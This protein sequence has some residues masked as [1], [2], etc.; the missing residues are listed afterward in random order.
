MKPGLTCLA[1]TLLSLPAGALASTASS[2]A[3]LRLAGAITP[4]GAC[5]M[6]VGNGVI[7]FE[8]LSVADLNPDHSKP[9]SLEEQR[10]KIRIDCESPRRYALVARSSAPVGNDELDFGL[11]SQSDQ[12][13]AGRLHLRFDSASAHIEGAR[14]YY[15]AADAAVD[16]ATAQWGPSTFSIL[17]VPNGAFAIGF[18]TSDGSYATPPPIAHFDTYLLVNP[19]IRPVN[20]L[21][22]SSEIAFSGSIGFEI[23]Y[24]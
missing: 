3:N 18:V 2:S 11:F 13:V 17:P 5:E 24:F 19:R 9:T 6:T 10:V 1:F 8:R 16:L 7:D 23:N 14:A 12:S 20:E 15:T 4:G 21:D 22:L